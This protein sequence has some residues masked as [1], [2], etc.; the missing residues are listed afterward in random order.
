[1]E[2]DALF[3]STPYKLIRVCIWFN[4]TCKIMSNSKSLGRG[5]RVKLI[6]VLQI[7]CPQP[8]AAVLSYPVQFSSV[9]SCPVLLW[10]WALI[11]SHQQIQHSCRSPSYLRTILYL[12]IMFCSYMY[13]I[14]KITVACNRGSQFRL[15][16]DYFVLMS[17]YTVNL[18]A[19]ELETALLKIVIFD[20]SYDIQTNKHTCIYTN[21]H[22]H[23]NVPGINRISW[24]MYYSCNAQLQCSVSPTWHDMARF[25][26]NRIDSTRISQLR[27]RAIL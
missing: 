22:A 5:L 27:R 14:R 23:R 15:C 13:S 19:N 20:V 18:L 16:L 11:S 4:P 7:I 25:C 9:Q 8:Q 2:G 6:L 26:S 3:D 24:N 17:V 12:R 1:M 21:I 10:C